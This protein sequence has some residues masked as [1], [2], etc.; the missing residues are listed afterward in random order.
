[1]IMKES[2]AAEMVG[3]IVLT[4]VI[5][6]AIAIVGYQWVEQIP[7]S[8]PPSV[9]LEIACGIP[10]VNVN[11]Y[12]CRSG[13]ISC[14]PQQSLSTAD[15]IAACPAAPD[16]DHEPCI[17]N[18]DSSKKLLFGECIKGCTQPG[19]LQYRSCI[20]S[21]SSPPNCAAVNDVTMCNMIFIC[22]N[23]GDSLNIET[24][25]ISINGINRDRPYEIYRYTDETLSDRSTGFFQAGEIL[26]IP[27]T[28]QP[29]SVVVSYDDFRSGQ[30]IVLSRKVF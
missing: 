15:C 14:E 1:M 16:P 20:D 30:N 27:I 17:W 7:L 18:C 10:P 24:L 28:V 2:A 19:T 13:I 21:C 3:A 9:K 11:D 12:S 25:G 5:A 6:A 26:R 8:S 22:H 23:G 29:D 4:S